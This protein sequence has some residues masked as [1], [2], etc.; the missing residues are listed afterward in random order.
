MGEFLHGWRRKLGVVTL[1]M[2]CLFMAGWV[3][4]L[5]EG[6]SICL[7]GGSSLFIMTSLNGSVGCYEF[8]GSDISGLKSTPFPS[9]GKQFLGDF[10]EWADNPLIT[11]RLRC[12]GFGVSDKSLRIGDYEVAIRLVPYWSITIPLTLLS[13]FLLLS[14]PR[15]STFNKTVEPIP[16]RECESW[17]TTSSRGRKAARGETQLKIVHS[18]TIYVICAKWKTYLSPFLRM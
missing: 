15:K 11:W 14:K 1:L 9:W 10:P 5:S 2:A 7:S 8:R 17:A 12:L 3:G 13:A 16:T 4:T 6:A 18:T